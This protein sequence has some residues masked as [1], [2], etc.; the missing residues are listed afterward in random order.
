MSHESSIC[1]FSAKTPIHGSNSYSTIQTTAVIRLNYYNKLYKS[2]QMSQGHLHIIISSSKRK[3]PFII[4][5]ELMLPALPFIGQ[6]SQ[7]NLIF[8]KTDIS[9]TVEPSRTHLSITRSPC[10]TKYFLCLKCSTSVAT[11]LQSHFLILGMLEL[12][13][14]HALYHC[15]DHLEW[16][17]IP[18]SK[19]PSKAVL[20]YNAFY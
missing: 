12:R 5:V 1:T 13:H 10:I 6:K 16:L 3:Q 15:L 18:R 19:P 14:P 8:P 9:T 20:L 7:N 17:L 11:L 4:Q 2:I